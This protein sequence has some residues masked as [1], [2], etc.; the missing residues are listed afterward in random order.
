MQR[1]VVSWF[2]SDARVSPRPMVGGRKIMPTAGPTL[3]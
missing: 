3:G 2:A 1:R